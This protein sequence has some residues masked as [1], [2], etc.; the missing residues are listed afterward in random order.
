MKLGIRNPATSRAGDVMRIGDTGLDEAPAERN[1]PKIAP[2]EEEISHSGLPCDNE[3]T[4]LMEKPKRNGLK[5]GTRAS[6]E[7]SERMRKVRN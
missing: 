1:L 6:E 5:E 3:I 2:E 7:R 4:V